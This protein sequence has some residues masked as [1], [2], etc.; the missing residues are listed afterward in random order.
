MGH[1]PWGHRRVRHDLVVKQPQQEGDIF[2]LGF[3]PR[4]F[5]YARRMCNFLGSVSLKQKFKMAEQCYSSVTAQSFI[6]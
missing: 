1:N 5:G 6:Q 3:L 2:S 4:Y